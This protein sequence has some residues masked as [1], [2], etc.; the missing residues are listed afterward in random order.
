MDSD[1]FKQEIVGCVARPEDRDHIIGKPEALPVIEGFRV[2]DRSDCTINESPIDCQY[3]ALSHVWGKT[4]TPSEIEDTLRLPSKV[5]QTIKD[6]IETTKA[7]HLR[8]LWVDRY[9][10]DETSNAVKYEH[11]MNM[12]KNYACAQTTLV[13]VIGN[14]LSMDCRAFPDLGEK[15]GVWLLSER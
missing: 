14:A 10:I 4:T 5:P 3:A 11:I 1:A 6:A 13:A 2:T 12:Q 9:C 7:L 15:H 8:Y